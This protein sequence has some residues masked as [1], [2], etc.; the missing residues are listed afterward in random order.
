[1]KKIIFILLF[2]LCMNNVK[3]IGLVKEVKIDNVYA[4]QVVNGKKTWAPLTYI[5]INGKI[6]YC[7]EPGVHLGSD[8]YY[9][10]IDF[11]SFNITE[12]DLLYLELIAYYGYE[13][14]GH[15]NQYYYMATQELIWRYLTSEHVYFTTKANYQGDI[16]DIEKYK[17]EILNLVNN[18]NTK[19]SFD[20]LIIEKQQ[21][22]LIT[23]IDSN[24]VLNSY[25]ITEGQATIKNNQLVINGLDNVTLEKNYNN[26]SYIYT[27][28]GS[29]RLI[30]LS[31]NDSVIASIRIEEK[32]N[33][34]Q[35]KI[36]KKDIDTNELIKEA[37]FKIKRLEDNTYIKI[38]NEEIL[39]TENGIL[40]LNNLKEGYY[41]IEEVEAPLGYLINEE[42][43]TIRITNTSQSIDV[44]NK[45][46]EMPQ[47]GYKININYTYYLLFFLSFYRS[48][49]LLK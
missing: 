10:T 41:E 25:K 34:Y 20:N 8:T 13:Y 18:H 42:L 47:T 33:D 7:I 29:Q 12:E 32:V 22:E 43:I 44:F 45:Q 28:L 15:N 31:L 30:T 23:L 16:I 48:R 17:N 24:N 9:E 4:N 2:F 36:Y 49:C 6:S 35:L 39:T 14:E 46:I 26:Q 40:I 11:N 1:M 38:N 19:P 27:S 3:A 21:N 37:Q 5:Y